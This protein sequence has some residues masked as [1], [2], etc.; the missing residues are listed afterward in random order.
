MAETIKE[1][2]S[3]LV[4]DPA[5]KIHEIWESSVL[6]PFAYNSRHPREIERRFVLASGARVEKMSWKEYRLGSVVLIRQDS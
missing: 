4:R 2:G 6:R 3:F 5:G 1:L